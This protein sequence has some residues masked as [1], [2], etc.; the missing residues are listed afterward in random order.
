MKTLQQFKETNILFRADFECEKIIN[1]IPREWIETV[2]L[3]ETYNEYGQEIGHL[4]AGD[5]CTENSEC[6]ATENSEEIIFDC[7]CLNYFN[8]SNWQSIIFSA[9]SYGQNDF[10][11]EISDAEYENIYNEMYTKDCKE[12]DLE[13]S[14]IF[15]FFDNPAQDSFAKYEIT[16]I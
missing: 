1:L 15:K 7:E 12:K 10:V 9:E 6:D 3:F 2:K 4:Q 13:E 5:Y 14:K 8:G 16:E 11:H